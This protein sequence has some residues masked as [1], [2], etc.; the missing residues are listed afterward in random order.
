MEIQAIETSVA[1]RKG[2]QH[3]P[4]P[5]WAS[6]TGPTLLKKSST[7]I[8]AVGLAGSAVTMG[9]SVPLGILA[10]FLSTGAC[11]LAY[12]CGFLLEEEARGYEDEPCC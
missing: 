8:L 4:S 10:G 3:A 7:M 12:G 1:E 9:A 11:A 2:G 5:A 6:P